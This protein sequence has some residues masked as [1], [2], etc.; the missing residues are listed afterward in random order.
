MVSCTR[1]VVSSTKPQPR[2]RLRISNTARGMIITYISMSNAASLAS[3]RTYVHTKHHLRTLGNDDEEERQVHNFPSTHQRPPQLAFL[4][5]HGT[6]IEACG[7]VRVEIVDM[8]VHCS[9]ARH[10]DLCLSPARRG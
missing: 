3:V 2:S 8:S 4:L 9:H 1:S 6:R 7:D 5:R 10:G